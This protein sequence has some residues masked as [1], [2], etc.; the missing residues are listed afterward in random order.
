MKEVVIN[1]VDPP[2]VYIHL[3]PWRCSSLVDKATATG[4][5]PLSIFQ[6]VGGRGDMPCSNSLKLARSVHRRFWFV[7]NCARHARPDPLLRV[8]L[9]KGFGGCISLLRP[10]S[11]F[12]NA[13]LFRSAGFCYGAGVAPCL[14]APARMKYRWIC[15]TC[16][17]RSVAPS[18]S[19]RRFVCL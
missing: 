1:Y 5:R 13:W 6:P 14:A 4:W 2:S 11:A 8:R 15:R 9:S 17:T 12:E 18:M 16:L 10:A 7:R 19:P 3:A